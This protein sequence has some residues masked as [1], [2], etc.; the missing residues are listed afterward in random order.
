MSSFLAGLITG[1]LIGIVVTLYARRDHQHQESHNYSDKTT[2]N[3]P[4]EELLMS[5]PV[6]ALKN[7]LVELARQP[8]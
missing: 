6:R 4:C 2:G 7:S 5:T 3:Q 8:R 1:S